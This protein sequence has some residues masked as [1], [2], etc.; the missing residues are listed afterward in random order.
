MMFNYA[1]G[2][3]H[4]TPFLSLLTTHYKGTATDISLSLVQKYAANTAIV[5]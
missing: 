1:E 3:L 5:R 4:L 2:T